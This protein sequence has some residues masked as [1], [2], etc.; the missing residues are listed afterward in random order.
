MAKLSLYYRGHTL[1]QVGQVITVKL[2]K[3]LALLIYLAV[4]AK[5]HTHDALATLLWPN[6]DQR[7]TRQALRNHQVGA[8]LVHDASSYCNLP[9]LS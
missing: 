2:C 4:T 1:G 8:H 6:S 7:K 3:A 9:M 5:R